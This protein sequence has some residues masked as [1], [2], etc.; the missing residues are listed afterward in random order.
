MYGDAMYGD[1]FIKVADRLPKQDELRRVRH[2]IIRKKSAGIM[3]DEL[4]VALAH[5]PQLESVVLSGVPSLTDRTIV[6]LASHANNLM[7][8][9]LSGCQNVTDIGILDVVSQALP[10][11][12]VMLNRVSGLTDPAISA[13]SRSCSRLIE[14]ELCY[15]PLLS[16]LSVRDI[17]TYSRKLRTLRLAYCR[18]LTDQA[19]PSTLDIPPS[20]YDSYEKPLPH[21]PVTLFEELPPLVLTHQADNLRILDIAYCNITDDAIEGIVHHA[22]RIQTL[23][24]SG[25]QLLTDR[26]LDAVATLGGHLD[27]LI[28]A[29]VPNISDLGV[30]NFTRNCVNLRCV[31][32]SFC[33]HLTD[34]SVFELASLECLRRLSLVRVHHLTDLGLSAIAEQAKSLERLHIDYCDKLTLD[35]VHLALKSLQNLEHLTAT[36]IPSLRRK[37]IKRFSDPPPSNLDVDQAAAFFVFNQEKVKSLTAFLTKEEMRRREAEAMNIS[38]SPRSDDLLDLY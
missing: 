12:W 25:C 27:V 34:M 29:H 17:W 13:I 23:N 19:F 14:L 38:F 21:R 8:L 2:L 36:G 18:M 24:L 16:P 26:A 4:A 28:L 31:D 10:L 3:D 6:T 15:L 35:G 37:G 32:V 30:V 7:G 5:C 11:Q 33:R 22:P 1:F 20:K 9:D